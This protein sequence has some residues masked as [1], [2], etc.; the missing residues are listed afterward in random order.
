MKTKLGISAGMM[1]AILYFTAL[2][3]GYVPLFIAAGYVL[4]KEENTFVRK[5]AFKSTI[6]AFCFFQQ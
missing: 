2:F 4:I 5:A 1:G 6:F 3:G